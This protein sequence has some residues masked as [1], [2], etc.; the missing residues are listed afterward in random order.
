[1]ENDTAAFDIIDRDFGDILGEKYLSYALSTIMS[2]S[3]PDVRDGLKPVHRRLLRRAVGFGGDGEAHAVKDIL[4]AGR[5]KDFV[6]LRE[7][8][9]RGGMI[10][11]Q[12]QLSGKRCRDRGRIALRAPIGFIPRAQHIMQFEEIDHPGPAV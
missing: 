12:L 9:G 11:P 3:L 10:T 4:V 6:D 8:G 2:R 7:I 1:M 5:G